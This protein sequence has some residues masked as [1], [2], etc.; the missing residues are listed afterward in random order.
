MAEVS[1]QPQP[2]LPVVASDSPAMAKPDDSKALTTL[3]P[4]SN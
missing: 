2:E 1:A 3:P 4:P